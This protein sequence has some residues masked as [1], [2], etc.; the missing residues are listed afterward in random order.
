[1]V[2]QGHMLRGDAGNRPRSRGRKSMNSPAAA[3]ALAA[4]E[5]RASSPPGSAAAATASSSG[6]V[7][8]IGGTKTT[9]DPY[10]QAA[11]KRSIV[12]LYDTCH[13]LLSFKVQCSELRRGRG[14]EGVGAGRRLWSAAS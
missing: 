4:G 14:R 11:L 8:E 2:G 7:S 12:G 9:E 6:G 13:R 10:V 3:T 5:P 1:M